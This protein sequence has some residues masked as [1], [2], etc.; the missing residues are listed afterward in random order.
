MQGEDEALASG[1]CLASPRVPRTSLTILEQGDRLGNVSVAQDGRNV[2]QGPDM[3]N[4]P[5]PEVEARGASMEGTVWAQCARSKAGTQRLTITV[6]SATPDERPAVRRPADDG[7]ARVGG[8][9]IEPCRV[10]E[11]SIRLKGAG[12]YV[13]PRPHVACA[14]SSNLPAQ[15]GAM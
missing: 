12:Q 10:F 7:M 3:A 1:W 9:A 5:A 8:F 4:L 15:P 14:C 6:P 13:I 11:P 2:E